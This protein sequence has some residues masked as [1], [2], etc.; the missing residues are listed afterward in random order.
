M[1]RRKDQLSVMEEVDQCI[2]EIEQRAA[3][4]VIRRLDENY[5]RINWP[6]MH[7]L[8]DGLVVIVCQEVFRKGRYQKHFYRTVLGRSGNNGTKIHLVADPNTEWPDVVPW[9]GVDGHPDWPKWI[10]PYSDFK[11]WTKGEIVEPIPLPI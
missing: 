2:V 5:L 3:A 11:G 1:S 7:Y 9:A 10:T 6:D 8:Q 4:E